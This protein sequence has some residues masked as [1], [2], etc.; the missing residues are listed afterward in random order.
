[1]PFD[2]PHDDAF[3][4]LNALAPGQHWSSFDV[5][6]DEARA[7]QAAILVTSIWN[8][9]SFLDVTGR[10]IPTVFAICQD[11]AT[12]RYWYRVDRPPTG[13][14]NRNW[15][16][17]WNRL[18]LAIDK[19]TP[20]VGVLKDVT[21]RRCSLQNVFD[22]HEAREQSDGLAI[23]LR[24][25]PRGTV[26]TSVR[27]VNI[28][29][30]TTDVRNTHGEAFEQA[31]NE[32]I[33]RTPEERL[34]RLSRAPKLPKAVTVITKVFVRNPDVIAQA[35]HRAKGKCEGCQR[36]APFFRQSDGSPYLEV[37]H[38]LPLSAGGED[39]LENAVALC[40]NCHRRIHYG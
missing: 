7:G 32:A 28:E 16:A 24:L 30:L 29:A 20:I 35:L 34:E 21:T 1:M 40:P 38:R 37:H 11:E 13:A 12:G 3:R 15:I 2:I 26:G 5:S 39:T 17:H 9:H 22:C 36:E 33:R 8:F 31:L 14:T 27:L 18:R 4:K 19:G 10:R 6:M 25:D 23:W